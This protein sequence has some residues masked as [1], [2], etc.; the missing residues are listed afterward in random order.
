MS[1]QHPARRAAT[2]ADIARVAKVSKATAAR[3]LGE[4]GQV[5]QAV[6]D[7]VLAAAEELDYRPNA[8]AKSMNTGRSNTIGV[9]VGDG[10]AV[11]DGPR[12]VLVGGASVT[13]DVEPGGCD[14]ATTS[15]TAAAAT[16]AITAT[17][18]TS[19]VRRRAFLDLSGFVRS[20]FRIVG[21]ISRECPR[22][23]NWFHPMET[24]S[25]DPRHPRAGGGFSRA[26]KWR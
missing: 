26:Q 1:P 2:V 21:L 15:T 12:A 4:Y 18:A 8:L 24:P 23:S 6:R 14:P 7:R 25:C 17:P 20:C 9:V 3:A 22:P 13:D 11:G 5:S 16:P 19:T 10:G